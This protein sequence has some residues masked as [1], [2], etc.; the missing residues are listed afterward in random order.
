V[1]LNFDIDSQVEAK[2]FGSGT[3]HS[4]HEFLINIDAAGKLDL[5]P[6]PQSQVSEVKVSDSDGF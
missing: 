5:W 6:T 1:K 4:P 3:S 2:G